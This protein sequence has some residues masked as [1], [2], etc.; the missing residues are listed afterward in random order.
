MTNYLYRVQIVA[1][2]EGA[3]RPTYFD[4]DLMVEDPSWKPEGWAPD[5]EWIERF[6]KHTGD[7]FF[8]PSTDR[9]YRSRSSA[10]K[11]KRLIESYG[12]KAIVQRSSRIVWPEDGQEYVR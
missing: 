5:E 10:M 11:R 1:Y 4:P 2:P 9:E 12:A 3:L 7:Q 6:G 8:W